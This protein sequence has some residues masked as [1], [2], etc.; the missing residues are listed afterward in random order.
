MHSSLSSLAFS[1]IEVD[2]HFLF[3]CTGRIGFPQHIY[4]P[5]ITGF[6]CRDRKLVPFAHY[7]NSIGSC[8]VGFVK[9]KG[10][11]FFCFGKVRINPVCDP[12]GILVNRI[13]FI[14]SYGD[15]TSRR[16]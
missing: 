10:K 13:L 4:L 7:R 11:Y 8:A 9:R 2:F 5:G 14:F 1:D 15:N 12:I 16:G 3:S 6:L